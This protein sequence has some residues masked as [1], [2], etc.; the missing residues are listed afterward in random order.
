MCRRWWHS[1]TLHCSPQPITNKRAVWRGKLLLD[2]R[3]LIKGSASQIGYSKGGVQ[4]NQMDGWLKPVQFPMC[5]GTD[6]HFNVSSISEM[7]ICHKII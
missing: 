5:P 1:T 2:E 4:A 3:S 7:V 6:L